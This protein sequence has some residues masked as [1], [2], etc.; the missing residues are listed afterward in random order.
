MI[1]YYILW[2]GSPRGRGG[3]RRRVFVSRL[4]RLRPPLSIGPLPSPPFSAALFPVLSR[5]LVVYKSGVICV[6]PVSRRCPACQHS[7]VSVFAT[8]CFA[9]PKSKSNGDETSAGGWKATE[10]HNTQD[11][12][13]ASRH[14]WWRAPRRG[15]P[16]SGQAN[17]GAWGGL[18]HCQRACRPL[19]DRS[20][21]NGIRPVSAPA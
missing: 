6:Q 7:I 15:L 18:H 5:P 8:S 20:A 4:R 10:T 9:T 1:L 21:R 13:L 14:S 11:V 3:R 16:G 12:L 17:P 19:S 2:R